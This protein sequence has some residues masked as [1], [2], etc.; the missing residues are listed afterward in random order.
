[1]IGDASSPIDTVLR[2]KKL[3]QQFWIQVLNGGDY[4]LIAKM[5]AP[6]YTYNGH[7]SPAEGT[8]KWLEGLRSAA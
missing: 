8:A 3:V 5:L 6:D 1:M 4:D 2:N 7:P